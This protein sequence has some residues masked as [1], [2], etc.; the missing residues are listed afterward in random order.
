MM[1]ESSYKRVKITL[2]EAY[3]YSDIRNKEIIKIT[4]LLFITLNENFIWELMAKTNGS[5]YGFR[6]K[7]SVIRIKV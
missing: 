2:L 6:H 1:K 3:S 5:I 4:N 7:R